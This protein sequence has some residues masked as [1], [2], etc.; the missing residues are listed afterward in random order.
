MRSKAGPSSKDLS[1]VE[2]AEKFLSSAEIG[3]AGFFTDSGSD[4]AKD[5]N[6]VAD[7]LSEDFRFGHSSD[8][9]VLKKYGYK[10]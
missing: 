9:D 10:E 1:S 6:K 4:G 8:A 2:A 7:A 3:I 5:F